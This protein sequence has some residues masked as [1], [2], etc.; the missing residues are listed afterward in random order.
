VKFFTCYQDLQC[1]DAQLVGWV[2]AIFVSSAPLKGLSG[3]HA[4]GAFKV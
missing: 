4:T 3:G 1:Q 2:P